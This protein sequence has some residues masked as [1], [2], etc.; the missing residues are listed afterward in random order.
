MLLADQLVGAGDDDEETRQK[1]HNSLMAL[2]IEQGRARF[3]VDALKSDS[4]TRGEIRARK[5]FSKFEDNREEFE[6][7]EPY[8][9]EVGISYE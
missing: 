5:R 2:A 9:N 4:T 1:A 8:K 7:T 6:G 3:M